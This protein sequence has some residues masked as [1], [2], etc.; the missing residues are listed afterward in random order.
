MTFLS[1]SALWGVG[2][3][4]VGADSGLQAETWRRREAA[5]AGGRLGTETAGTL[6][7]TN[8]S[9]PQTAQWGALASLG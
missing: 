2:G 8:N 6:P 7:A 9:R 1:S 4:G 3:G 5:M